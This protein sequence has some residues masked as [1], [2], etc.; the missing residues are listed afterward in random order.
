MK[1]KTRVISIIDCEENIKQSL[2]SYFLLLQAKLKEKWIIGLD[3]A[4]ADV[5]LYGSCNA[6][7][8][9]HNN[10]VRV[11]LTFDS[12]QTGLKS[13]ESYT[14]TYPLTSSKVI[15]IFN[16]ISKN[17]HPKFGKLHNKHSI[18]NVFS[19]LMRQLPQRQKKSMETSDNLLKKN[20]QSKTKKSSIADKLLNLR[21]S[22]SKQEHSL[23]FV[24]VGS[25]NAG[26]T[27]AITSANN[28]K[29]LTSE[30][31]ATDSVSFLKEQTTIGIDYGEYHFEQTQLRL[32]GTP[33]QKR[34]HYIQNNV[35]NNADAYLILIDLSNR[36]P[37]DDFLYFKIMV[38]KSSNDKAVLAVI[39]THSDEQYQAKSNIT[40]KLKNISS[41][42]ILTFTIDVRKENEIRETLR[43]VA[44]VSRV[45]SR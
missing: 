12:S 1:K 21:K 4:P 43:E 34:Y 15:Q 36:F 44:K 10:A 2:A 18:R 22:K 6:I 17:E 19:G 27:T 31:T 24:L 30:V 23:K 35:I 20:S 37:I 38:E 26:K 25:P 40:D 45:R 14:L 8:K 42:D 33:G 7:T 9:T 39:F 11:I 5:V 32:F 28:R 29:M 41:K 16:I 13:N 3:T